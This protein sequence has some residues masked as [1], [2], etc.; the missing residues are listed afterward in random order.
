MF[1]VQARPDDLA[2]SLLYSSD[3]RCSKGLVGIECRVAMLVKTIVGGQMNI[4]GGEYLYMS[5]SLGA[6]WSDIACDDNQV[7]P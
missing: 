5:D 1:G 3:I 4:V 2:K 6:R 7:L